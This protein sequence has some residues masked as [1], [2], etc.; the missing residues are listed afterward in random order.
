M[1]VV[2]ASQMEAS[3]LMAHD[4]CLLRQEGFWGFSTMLSILG[5]GVRL[6]LREGSK[7]LMVMVL[8]RLEMVELGRKVTEKFRSPTYKTIKLLKYPYIL[9]LWQRIRPSGTTLVR[10]WLRS[11]GGEPR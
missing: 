2:W 6:K 1:V 11:D 4:G 7:G 3:K 9:R 10:A 8:N 5:G